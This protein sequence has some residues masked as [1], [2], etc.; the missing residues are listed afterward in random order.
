MTEPELAAFVVAL[1]R[2]ADR[3]FTSLEV[4][5]DGARFVQPPYADMR[6]APD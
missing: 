6:P 3:T 4:E 5:I 2:R 1:R